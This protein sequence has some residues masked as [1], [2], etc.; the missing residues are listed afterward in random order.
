[1]I[2]AGITFAHPAFDG[3][4][5]GWIG[6]M[7]QKP[8]TEDYVPL[9]PWTGVAADR[10][11]GRPLACAHGFAI[12]RAAC[13]CAVRRCN[14]WAGTASCFILSISRFCSACCGSSCVDDNARDRTP[15]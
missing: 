12:A 3:R 7:T 5:L 10:I 2:V 9:F 14:G 11:R 4:A 15:T 13:A 8:V 1:M 6:F